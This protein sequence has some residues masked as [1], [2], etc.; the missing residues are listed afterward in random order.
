MYD[1]IFVCRN[2]EV[3]ILLYSLMQRYLSIIRIFTYYAEKKIHTRFIQRYETEIVLYLLLSKK[4]GF[5]VDKTVDMTKSVHW[6]WRQQHVSRNEHILRNAVLEHQLWWW[7]TLLCM[8]V[9]MKRKVRKCNFLVL[10][11]CF[12]RSYDVTFYSDDSASK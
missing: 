9:G 4:H 8:N 12:N 5:L 2:T 10:W 6:S 3:Y 7:K 11:K 1:K